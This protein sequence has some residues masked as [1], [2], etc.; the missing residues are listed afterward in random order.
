MRRRIEGREDLD[1][2]TS[3]DC[4]LCHMPFVLC[5]DFLIFD[6]WLSF[7]CGCFDF[8]SGWSRPWFVRGFKEHGRKIEGLSKSKVKL[9]ASSPLCE[10]SRLCHHAAL[11]NRDRRRI[12]GREEGGGP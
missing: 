10:P 11:S 3:S 8:C 7:F 2:P 1:L 6:L 12:G 5:F 9:G 4:A